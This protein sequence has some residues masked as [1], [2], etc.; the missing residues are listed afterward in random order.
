MSDTIRHDHQHDG[1]DRR[2][3]LKCMAWAGTG[4][5]WTLS[6]GRVSSTVLA[7]AEHTAPA[8]ATA[9]FSFV[10]ISDSHIGF[11]LGANKHVTATFEEAVQRINTLP[12]RPAFVVH[13]GDHVH[14]STLGEF[15]TT[16]QIMGT[17]K[18]DRTFN[19]PGEHDVFVDH[20]KRYLQT[21]GKGAKGAGYYSFDYNGV[22]FLALANV[23][24]AE[25][26]GGLTGLGLLGPAQLDFVKKDLAPLSADTPLVIF[27]HVPLLA[28]YP[29]WGWGTVD[30]TQVLALVKRFSSVTALNG[31]IH[32]IIS[33]TE[34]NVVMHTAASTAYPL[35]APGKVAPTPLVLPAGELPAR[36]G[37]RTVQFVQGTSS[38]ALKDTSFA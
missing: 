25:G 2:G 22:H 30:S 20:G 19:V 35:H 4:V 9:D 7:A 5:L 28:V 26:Q 17:I 33:K 11:H 6:A 36:I 21:F 37:I 31:H 10:Q 15:D 12:Q 1:V 24:Q 27:S 23:Q 29:K 32:Q 8:Q 3:F 38:L 18:T 34:G 14:L 16:K 13:T